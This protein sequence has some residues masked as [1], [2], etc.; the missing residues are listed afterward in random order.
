MLYCKLKIE[1]WKIALCFLFLFFIF[2][3]SAHAGLIIKLPSSLGLSTGLV[4]WWTFD[5][6]DIS[7]TTVLDKSGNGNNGTLT[8]DPTKA[9]GKIG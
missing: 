4:G 6:P 2:T 1:N 9:I 7:G 5:G 8:N 3:P